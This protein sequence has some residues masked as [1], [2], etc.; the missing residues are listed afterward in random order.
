MLLVILYS[1]VLFAAGMTLALFLFQIRLN[2]ML[3][4]CE[5]CFKKNILERLN[6]GE[7]KV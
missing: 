2:S 1:V 3:E 5:E 7:R 6:D 4:Q